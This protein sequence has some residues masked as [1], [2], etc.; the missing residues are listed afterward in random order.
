MTLSECFELMRWDIR[1]NMGFSF[2]RIRA[3][4]LMVEVRFEQFIYS[5]AQMYPNAFMK[6]TWMIVRFLGS[7]YQ[8]FLC[9]SS[10]SGSVKVGRGLRLPHPQNL[11][12]RYHADIGEFCTIYHNVSIVWNG[13][14]PAVPCSPKIGNQ[15]LIGSGA[16]VIGDIEIGDKVLIGAGA[17]V[18]KSVP[19]CS[20]VTL[21]PPII[22]QREFSGEQVEAG[23][24]KHLQD[25]YSI[26]R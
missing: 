8:W 14:V 16:I 7:I 25:P 22:S 5:N 6:F 3:I 17:V 23:S 13:F 9:N 21:P 15:V 24:E 4:L 18:S 2:D 11:I 12:I 19:D 20:R 1:V 26:W 10:I